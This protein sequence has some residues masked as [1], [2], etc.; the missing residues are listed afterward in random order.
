[1]AQARRCVRVLEQAPA[2]GP[3]TAYT[4]MDAAPGMDAAVNKAGRAWAAAKAPATARDPV[5][6]MT[7]ADH[8]TDAATVPA[9][10]AERIPTASDKPW[11]AFGA[12]GQPEASC[13]FC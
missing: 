4:G 2:T 5:T 13:P 1:M 8:G 7:P 9:T 6:A 10:D 11:A 12:G 3:D